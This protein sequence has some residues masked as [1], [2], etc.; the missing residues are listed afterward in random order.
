MELDIQSKG[1]E[2]NREVAYA[3]VGSSP[4]TLL[5]QETEPGDRANGS[6]PHQAAHISSRK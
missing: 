2:D 6:C 3:V 1:P 4:A 5:M